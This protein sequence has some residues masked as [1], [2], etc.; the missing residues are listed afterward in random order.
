MAADTHAITTVQTA[1]GPSF[2]KASQPWFYRTMLKR[3]LDLSLVLL[4]A[5]VIIPLILLLAV[6]VMRDGGNPF[7][8]QSRIGRNGRTYRMWKLRSMVVDADARLQSYL[9]AN[10]EAR[11]EWDLTQKLRNDPRVTRFG[12]LLRACSM[13]ELPQL[14]NVVKGEMS[15]IGPRPMLP[16]QQAMYSGDAYFRL[17]PGITGLWQVAGRNRTSFTDR[18]IYDERYDRQL[19]LSSDA[20]ILMRTVSVVLRRT[21]C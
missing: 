20:G 16:E 1:T 19:S 6:L 17:R 10:P 14:W 15:L 4:A 3:P 21:G 7:Y 9:D 18:A 13:D 5:P 2:H 8:T 12:R 11:A